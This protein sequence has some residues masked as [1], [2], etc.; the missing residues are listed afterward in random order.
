MRDDAVFA[1][2]SET[3]MLGA[4]GLTYT[5]PDITYTLKAF[6]GEAFTGLLM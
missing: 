2:A 6:P 5:D 4:G 1:V 3:S